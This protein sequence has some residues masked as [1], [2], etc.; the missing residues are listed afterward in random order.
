LED[1]DEVPLPPGIDPL[2]LWHPPPDEEPSN[3][4]NFTTISVD[5][6]LVR[7]LRPHQR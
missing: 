1:K 3:S 7:F 4:N 5:P 6:L 2:I